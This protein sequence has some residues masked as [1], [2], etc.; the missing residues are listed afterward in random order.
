[1]PERMPVR[2]PT[3]WDDVSGEFYLH[4]FHFQECVAVLKSLLP[5]VHG[6]W[7]MWLDSSLARNWRRLLIQTNMYDCVTPVQKEH[8]VVCVEWCLIWRGFPFTRNLHWMQVNNDIARSLPKCVCARVV[9]S[10]WWFLFVYV[11]HIQ[12]FTCLLWVVFYAK[13]VIFVFSEQG[14]WALYFEGIFYFILFFCNV[15]KIK[16]FHWSNQI[17]FSSVLKE[18]WNVLRAGEGGSRRSVKFCVCV[19]VFFGEGCLY[20]FQRNKSGETKRKPVWSLVW[21]E[22][23]LA[24]KISEETF[25]SVLCC[26]K[27]KWL[28][29]L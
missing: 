23:C 18:K 22:I 3:H 17:L 11:S 16:L 24:R 21:M 25:P 1:M 9:F 10:V 26:L 6:T 28:Q 27:C 12:R 14:V 4:L 8:L 7:I 5:L 2:E 15:L 29:T 20:L 19:S 13:R